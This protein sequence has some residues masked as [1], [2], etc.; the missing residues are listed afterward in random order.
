MTSIN[1]D[2]YRKHMA[3][4]VSEGFSLDP[5]GYERLSLWTYVLMHLHN[6]RANLELVRDHPIEL[7]DLNNVIKQQAFFIAG[8]MAYTRC[9]VSSGK[10]IPML[11]AKRVYAGSEDGMAVHQRLIRLRNTIAA[12]T[13]KSDLV[14]LTLA[15]KDEPD[16]VIVRHIATVATPTNEIPDFLEAVAHTEHFVTIALN[17]QLDHLEKRIGKAISLD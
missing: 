16:R 10:S 1:E 6:A 5:P 8:I 17:K 2:E 4:L 15:V 3:G 12:H 7:G 11:D 13:E 14:R 9:Y